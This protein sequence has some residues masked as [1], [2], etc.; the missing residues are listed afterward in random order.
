MERHYS[1]FFVHIN[2]PNGEAPGVPE[3]DDTK[4]KIRKTMNIVISPALEE[5][6]FTAEEIDMVDNNI[7]GIVLTHEDA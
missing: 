3:S 7:I 1:E 5:Y 2:M 4:T 6:G